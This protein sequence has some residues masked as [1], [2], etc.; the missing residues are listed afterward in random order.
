MRR[1]HKKEKSG[2]QEDETLEN[3]SAVP[4]TKGQCPKGANPSNRNLIF[5]KKKM[6]DKMKFRDGNVSENAFLF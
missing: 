5:R 6:T 2:L 3:N 4:G 1:T